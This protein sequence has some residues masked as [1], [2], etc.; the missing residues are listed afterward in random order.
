MH[1]L[2]PQSFLGLPCLLGALACGAPPASSQPPA[3]PPVATETSTETS[4]ASPTPAEDTPAILT[5]ERI[6]VEH[7]GCFMLLD[8]ATN[9][10]HEG[11]AQPCEEQTSPASTFKI[12]HSLIALDTGVIVDP[13]A[14]RKWDGTEYRHM[15]AWQHDHSLRTAI[16]DSV[17]WVFQQTAK[18]IGRERMLEYLRAWQYGNARVEEPIDSFWLREEDGVL[19]S[20]LES[21][22]FLSM[23]YRNTLPMGDTHAPLLKE[24]LV[25]PPKSF[26]GRL[27]DDLVAP[28]IDPRAVFSAKTGTGYHNGGSVTWIVGHVQCPERAH[29]FV[30]R[31]T[32]PDK[33]G[34][35]SPAV[36]HGLGALEQLGVLSCAD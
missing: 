28:A 23:L 25:R 16:Y 36:Q 19:I 21:L 12:P 35:V 3:S 29:V 5:A 8:L 32:S 11:G 9:T 18:E 34:R 7:P 33:P 1:R 6:E 24:M 31:V 22:R 27:P 4:T 30:S 20:G 14:K 15:E 17:V 2:A 26:N 13:D 10:V